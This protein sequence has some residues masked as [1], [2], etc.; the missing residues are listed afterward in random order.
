MNAVRV[1]LLGDWRVEFYVSPLKTTKTAV[2]N[3]WRHASQDFL[4]AKVDVLYEWRRSFSIRFV[5]WRSYYLNP[6]LHIQ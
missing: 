4:F 5:L 3:L 2:A 1:L 6:I